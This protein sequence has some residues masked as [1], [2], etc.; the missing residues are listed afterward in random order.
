[1]IIFSNASKGVSHDK[2]T[3]EKR[4]PIRSWLPCLESHPAPVLAVAFAALASQTT[5]LDDLENLGEAFC[6]QV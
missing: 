4:M 1:M 3:S 2:Q 5:S 6:L